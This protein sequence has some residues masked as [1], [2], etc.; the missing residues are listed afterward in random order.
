MLCVYQPHSEQLMSTCKERK[1]GRNCK[2]RREY[3][4][5]GVGVGVGVGGSDGD[6]GCG[7]NLC[8]CTRCFAHISVRPALLLQESKRGAIGCMRC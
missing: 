5:A 8:H 2:G 6:G 1:V 3:V 4:V 7:Q